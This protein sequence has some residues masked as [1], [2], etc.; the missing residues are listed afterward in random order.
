MEL[1]MKIGIALALIACIINTGA[2]MAQDGRKLTKVTVYNDNLGV[3]KEIREMNIAKGVS[4]V[5]VVDVA[6][7][8][9]PSTVHINL[10]GVVLEQ[11][12]QY[13]LVSLAKILQRYIDKDITLIGSENTIFGTLLSVSASQIVLRQKDGGLVMLPKYEDYRISVGS[14]P[15]GLITKPTLVWT[16]DSKKSGSQNVEMSYQTR[17]MDWNCQYVAVL[18]EN[19]TKMDLN[20]WVSVNNNSGATFPDAELKLVAG[21]VNRVVESKMLRSYADATSQQ[22]APEMIEEREF[23]EYHIY[24]LQRKTTLKNN[25]TKQISLFET[26]DVAVEKKFIHRA[27]RGNE[28]NVEIEFINSKENNMGM[29][30]PKGIVRLNKSEA[31]SLEFVGEDEI[32]HTP[33]NEKVSLKVGTAFDVQVEERETDHKKISKNVF[34][35]EIELKIKNRKDK[36]IVVECERYLGHNW[37]ILEK[38]HEYEKNSSWEVVFKVPAKADSET[39]LIYKVRYSN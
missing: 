5:K 39:I 2:L 4:D 15:E 35:R 19:D 14:L 29:P 8:I 30:L 11:N 32:D 9:K 36:D 17:G 20:A 24:E 6:E 22:A 21:E 34:E 27:Y 7:Q 3:V 23:F 28:V 13:D 31:G 25:E 37:E 1:N 18:N 26:K 12:Y 33:K 10:D 38:T 16:V